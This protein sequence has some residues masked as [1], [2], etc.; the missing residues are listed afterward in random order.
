MNFLTEGLEH[1]R[2]LQ[3]QYKKYKTEQLL[4]LRPEMSCNLLIPEE[5]YYV[6]PDPV[7]FAATLFARPQIIL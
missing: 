3:Y 2:W 7:G 6:H 5:M 1:R 4:Y